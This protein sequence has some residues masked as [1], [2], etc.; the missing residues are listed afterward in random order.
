MSN[1]DMHTI[2]KTSEKGVTKMESTHIKS[3]MGIDQYG[4]TYHSLTNPR[5][6]L[7]KKLG[8]KSASKM[9]IDKKDGSTKHVGY[10]IGHNWVTLY[11][12]S[13]FEKEAP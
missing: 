11:E 7:M 1:V 13:P 9:Y 3:Y 8:M 10:I 12:V 6:D 4:Q 2:Q 5:K